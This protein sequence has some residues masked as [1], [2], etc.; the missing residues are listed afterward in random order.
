[1]LLIIRG[2]S[3]YAGGS[4]VLYPNFRR[5]RRMS[6]YIITT[7]PVLLTD[8]KLEL[9]R[10]EKNKTLTAMASNLRRKIL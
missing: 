7:L 10:Y 3:F 2:F 8:V 9:S 6:V 1:M 5:K 4:G